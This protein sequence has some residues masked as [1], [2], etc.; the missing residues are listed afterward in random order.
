[1]V[2][3]QRTKTEVFARAKLPVATPSDLRRAGVY[4]D[5]VFYPGFECNGVGIGTD[6][7]VRSYREAKV[8]EIKDVVITQ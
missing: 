1:M 3:F 4:V 6:I 2:W 7:F 8:Q 5:D